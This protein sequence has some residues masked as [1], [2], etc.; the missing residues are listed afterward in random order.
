MRHS[1]EGPIF[2]CV[3]TNNLSF[4]V[5]I[6]MIYILI[7]LQLFSVFYFLKS[8]FLDAEVDFVLFT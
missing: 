1:Q 7:N 8:Y 4:L 2:L 5:H 6:H 3:Y